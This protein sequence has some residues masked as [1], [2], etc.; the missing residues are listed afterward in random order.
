MTMLDTDLLRTFITIVDEGGFT[1]AGEVLMRSQSTVSLQMQRLEKAVGTPLFRREGRRMV[2]TEHGTLLLGYARR[3]LNIHDE[4]VDALQTEAV[5]GQIR[6][7]IAQD[8][9]LQNEANGTSL[10]NPGISG[11]HEHLGRFA[12]AHPN[13]DINVRVGNDKD[14][15]KATLDRDL[16]MCL[17]YR[18]RNAQPLQHLRHSILGHD[19]LV[20]IAGTDFPAELSEPVPLVFHEPDCPYSRAAAHSLDQEG[21]QWQRVYQSPSLDG[22]INA[23]RCGLGLTVRS[24]RCLRPGLVILDEGLPR[25]PPLDITLIQ[26]ESSDSPAQALFEQQLTDALLD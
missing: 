9:L 8:F 7:G 12:R 2:L 3:M 10:S 25:F 15:I 22:V 18:P 11:L 5:H 21:I 14:L 19:H 24:E 13:I 23:V 20:W 17:V 26:T 16:D 6:L 1:R 4:A